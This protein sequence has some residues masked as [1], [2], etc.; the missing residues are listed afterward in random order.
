MNG[1]RIRDLVLGAL[2]AGIIGHGLYT[3]VS[4]RALEAQVTVLQ[5]DVREL[6]AEV[7]TL[8]RGK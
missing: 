1:Q 3:I 8:A 2:L 5:G 6:R 4:T 7:L